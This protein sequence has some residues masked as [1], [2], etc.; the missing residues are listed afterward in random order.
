[1]RSLPCNIDLTPNT[2]RSVSLTITDSPIVSVGTDRRLVD[3]EETRFRV[4]ALRFQES[5]RP[6]A[7]EFAKEL[8]V[9]LSSLSD[10]GTSNEDTLRTATHC[11]FDFLD[12]KS[13]RDC[14][15]LKIK[16]IPLSI[17]VA[18]L[19]VFSLH[20]S[21]G[22]NGSALS[23]LTLRL[24]DKDEYTKCLTHASATKLGLSYLRTYILTRNT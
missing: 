17:F 1:M 4:H 18:G 10:L 6:L 3:F 22:I 8:G 15:F 7:L 5:L 13:R 12:I 9:P 20:A 23:G 14:S 21:Y 16:W 2:R 11:T 19:R 24:S